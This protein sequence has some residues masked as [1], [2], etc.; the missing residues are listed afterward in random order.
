LAHTV[1]IKIYLVSFT[2]FEKTIGLGV[3]KFQSIKMN[4]FNKRDTF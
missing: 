4:S 3:K 1:L 2:E